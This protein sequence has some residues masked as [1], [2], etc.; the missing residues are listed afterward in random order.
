MPV[1]EYQRPAELP[2]A[3][4]LLRRP[5]AAPL[6]FGPRVPDEPLAGVEMA[7]DVSQLGLSYIQ[8]TQSVIRIGAATPLQAIAEALEIQ[9]EAGGLLA[10]A[11]RLAAPLTLRNLATL[12]GALSATGGP[13]EVRLALLVMEA[14]RAP[15]D[16]LAEVVVPRSPGPGLGAAL[17]RVARSPR[18]EAIVAAAAK[19]YVHEGLCRNVRLAVAGAHPQPTRLASVEALLEGQ[20]WGEERAHAAAAQVTAGAQPASDHRGSAEYRQALAGTLAK[21]ALTEA[22]QRAQ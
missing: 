22:W 14:T 6:M 7:V 13:P 4:A 12:G 11:V 5:G 21:R 15:G 2:T 17:V 20:P 3:Q 18:D 1:R 19:L 8:V 16:P 10:Q 9:A